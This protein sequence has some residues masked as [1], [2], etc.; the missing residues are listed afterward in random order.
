MIDTLV[1]TGVGGYTGDGGP[2]TAARIDRPWGIELDAAGDL[3]IA[4]FDNDAVRRVSGGIITTVAGTGTSGYNGDGILATTARLNNPSDVAIDAA[5]NLYIADH[6]NHRI[7]RVDAG[8]LMI[9]TVAGTGTE[10]FG[11]DGGPATA[12]LLSEPMDVKVD[13]TGAVWITDFQNQRVRR[14]TVGGTIE[15]VAGTGLRGY[16]GDGGLATAA[17][18]HFPFRLFVIAS[19]KVLVS[20]RNNFVVRGLGTIAAGCATTTTSSSTSTSSSSSSSSSTSPASSTTST[21]DGSSSSSTS[22]ST[23]PSPPTS[24]TSSSSAT[25]LT[26]ATSTTSTTE[27]DGADLDCTGTGA[28]RCIPGG[29][30]L[31]QDCFGEFRVEA[32]LTNALPPPRLTCVDG[33][34]DCDADDVVGQCTF[35]VSLC[36]NNTDVRLPCTPAAIRTVALRGPPAGS[37]GGQSLLQGI[38]A[39]GATARTVRAVTFD[40]VLSDANRCTPYG[41]FVVRRGRTR[42]AVLRAVVTTQAAGRD[43]NRLKLVCLAP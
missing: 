36:L 8:T 30:A 12:A 23:M 18:L 1:G 3:Y 29:K 28:A 24:T 6:H 42:A 25:T 26:V 40:R 5:G 14:F 19:D 17:R 35:R 34:A 27:P 37:P 4:D 21:S 38:A 20:E 31:A 10:G 22:S 33:D 13:E 41:D 2:A 15:T 43:R 39:L 16:E 11:G 7:R 32:S 9:T